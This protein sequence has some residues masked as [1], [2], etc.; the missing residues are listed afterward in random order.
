MPREFHVQEPGRRQLQTVLMVTESG[1]GLSDL[2]LSLSKIRKWGS[3]LYLPVQGRFVVLF[4]MLTILTSYS[5]FHFFHT[6][7]VASSPFHLSPSHSGSFYSLLRLISKHAESSYH[8]LYTLYPYTFSTPWLVC[9]FLN[10]ITFCLSN[11]LRPVIGNIFAL[12]I[13][14]F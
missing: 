8:E 1:T 7:C 4:K 12:I 9:S 2:T 6:A 5:W 10:F 13:F 11:P 3:L 14:L